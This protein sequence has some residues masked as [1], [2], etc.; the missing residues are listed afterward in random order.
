MSD[1]LPVPIAQLLSS[2]ID[3]LAP[4]SRR[5]FTAAAEG[6][7]EALADAL[8]A[9]A[10]CGKRLAGGS[11]AL[12]IACSQGHAHCVRV[13][14]L[15]GGPSNLL[16]RDHSGANALHKAASWGR[17]DCARALLEAHLDASALLASRD[18]EGRTPFLRA[19]S[20][21]DAE[22]LRLLMAGS[23]L[24]A[25]D[26][27]GA[28]AL[29]LAAQAGQI[30]AIEALLPFY[31]IDV[32]NGSGE[33]PL[34]CACVCAQ[35]QAAAL[36]NFPGAND[37]L[38]GQGLTPLESLCS[39]APSPQPEAAP[40]DPRGSVFNELECCRWLVSRGAKL[41]PKAGAQLGPLDWACVMGKTALALE[42]IQ[43][44]NA[45]GL[46]V[47]DLCERAWRHAHL[48]NHRQLA[49]SVARH[50]AS[51]KESQALGAHAG[52]GSCAGVARL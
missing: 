31:P 17:L 42:V 25:L 40:S 47:A 15:H 49:D 32:R 34:H 33:T 13:L 22:I 39:G 45:Q 7:H 14:A 46:D 19:A 44:A 2:R 24:S 21:G 12:M 23:D 51:W 1:A 48:A 38:D 16:A 20:R 9:G 5:L 43:A 41:A 18:R 36:L 37:S 6:D 26:A 10:D 3:E 28:C 8:A 27:H 29:H 35:P 50:G 52:A 11:T 30:Q 4:L